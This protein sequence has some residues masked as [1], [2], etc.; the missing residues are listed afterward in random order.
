MQEC[1]DKQLKALSQ[2]LL[3]TSKMLTQTIDALG[4]LD[5]R[6]FG[7]ESPEI[8]HCKLMIAVQLEKNLRLTK[9]HVMKGQT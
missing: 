3:Q 5:A 7:K 6:A 9:P 4:E 1:K 8:T 2:A